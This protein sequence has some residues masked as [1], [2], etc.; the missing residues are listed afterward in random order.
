[1]YFSK[2]KI[3]SHWMCKKQTSVSHSST[4][5]QINSLD[6]GLRMDGLLV[7]DLWDVVIEALRSC[8]STKSP[9][10]K[11]VAGNCVR[12]P[13]RDRTFQTQTKGKPRR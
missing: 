5:S 8:N 4:E 11:P 7:L 13:E 2:P 3:C 1:M 10:T 9:K 12:D 6:A